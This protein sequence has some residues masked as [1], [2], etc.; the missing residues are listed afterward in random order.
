[1]N[2]VIV[3]GTNHT[4]APLEFREQLALIQTQ[5]QSDDADALCQGKTS[6]QSQIKLGTW[7]QGKYQIQG[8]VTLSTCNRVEIYATLPSD[9]DPDQLRRFVTESFQLEEELVDKYTYVY[10]G[11][12]AILHLFL[13]SSSLDSMIGSASSRE[14]V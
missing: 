9:Q 13:V 12:V 8:S 11:L 6:D 5:N 7:L 3:M 4:V 1:M 2:K 14:R 10:E